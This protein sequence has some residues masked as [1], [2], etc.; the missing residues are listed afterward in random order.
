MKVPLNVLIVEDSATDTKLVVRELRRS[1]FAP[2]WERVDTAEDLRSALRRRK[3]QIVISDSS[4]P[5]LKTLQA[6]SVTKELMP[7]L[8]VIVLSGL[9]SEKAAAQ[10]MRSGAAA[11]LSKDELPRLGPVVA[12]FSSVTRGQLKAQD[13]ERR[14]LARELHDQVGQVLTAIR[15]NLELAQRERGARHEAAI[16]EALTLLNQAVGQVRDFALELWP[17][18]LDELGLPAAVRWLAARQKRWSGLEFHLDL[19]NVGALPQ[20]V[21]AAAFRIVQEAL[22]NVARHAKAR[23]VEIRLRRVRGSLELLV[24]D[25]GQGFDIGEARKRADSSATLGL[26]GM[27][28]RASLAG[29]KL[30]I[31]SIKGRGTSVRV[32]FPV[33]ARRKP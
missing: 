28:E 10:V 12:R 17:T 6:L 5:Q 21:E 3:W 1:G 20:E 23:R 26:A 29:G 9:A 27:E 33:P 16:A 30:E 25:D 14:R 18:I 4:A 32:R 15:L 22:T 11:Y 19:G 8:P 31:L 7:G 2:R 24:R 13:A